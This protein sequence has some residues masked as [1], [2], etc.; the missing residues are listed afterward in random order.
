M[1]EAIPIDA[2]WE[3]P[4]NNRKTSQMKKEEFNKE[5]EKTKKMLNK[6]LLKAPPITRTNSGPKDKMRS[7]FSMNSLSDDDTSEDSRSLSL[8]GEARGNMLGA[9]QEWRGVSES[10]ADVKPAGPKKLA[11]MLRSSGGMILYDMH[12]YVTV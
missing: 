12:Q 9:M 8:Q 5:L 7:L 11:A 2:T 4:K 1:E 6:N 10:E 3:R